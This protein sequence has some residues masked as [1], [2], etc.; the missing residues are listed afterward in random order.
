MRNLSF[1]DSDDSSA[2]G[3]D[4]SDVDEEGNI[5]DVSYSNGESEEEEDDDD[6]TNRDGE[7]VFSLTWT[8]TRP[9]W[10][11]LFDSWT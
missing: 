4:G 9:L 11:R 8:W 5:L 1:Q 10:A 7:D 3:S 2:S 6:A